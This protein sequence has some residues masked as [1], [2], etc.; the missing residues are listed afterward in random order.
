MPNDKET[1]TDDQ[2]G[3]PSGMTGAGRR[4]QVSADI[5]RR[6]EEHGGKCVVVPD[7]EERPLEFL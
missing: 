3:P 2:E 7:P 5:R 4:T 1:T 6:L